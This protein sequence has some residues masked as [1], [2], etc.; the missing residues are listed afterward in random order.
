M[1]KTP[2]ILVV[3]DEE[4]NRDLLQAMLRHLGYDVVAGCDGVEGQELV[5]QHR[6]DLVITD[7]MMPK[8]NGYDF[9]NWIKSHEETRIRLIPVIMLTGLNSLNDRVRGIEVGADDFITKPFE[10]T[11]L[12][13]RVSS[14]IKLKQFTDDLENAEEVIFTLALTVEAKDPYTRGHCQRLSE[15]GMDIGRLLELPAEDIQA[16]R[17][18]GILHDIG[19][20]GIPDRIL[21]KPGPLTEAEREIMRQHPSKGE[22]ICQ[23][24]GSLAGTLPIIRHHHE[25]MD[26]RGYPDGLQAD[27]IYIGARI[28]AVVD[29]YD[30]LVTDRPYREALSQDRALSITYSAAAE[31]HLDPNIVDLLHEFVT[32]VGV[33]W[34]YIE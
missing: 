14:L 25:R 3:E 20:I 32:A 5:E 9:C 18:G 31:G 15:H 26:G 16:I 23:P 1:F 13:A 11:E 30:A 28:I 27:D 2:L 29:F 4:P 22:E 6:P 17:R 34:L 7:V 10:H 21:L 24:L 12:R 19:K 33:G 8:L